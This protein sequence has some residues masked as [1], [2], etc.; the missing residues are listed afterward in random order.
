MRSLPV[1]GALVVALTFAAPSALAA[2]CDVNNCTAQIEAIN[3][4]VINDV[5]TDANGNTA[6]QLPVYGK[7]INNWPNCPE[8]VDFAGAGHSIAPFDC[9]SQYVT[10]ATSPTVAAGNAFLGAVDRLWWQPCRLADPTLSNGCVANWSCIA[11]GL[12]GNYNPWQGLV[13]DLGGPS[14]RVAVFAENDHGPQPCESLEYTVY[15]SDNPYA[16]DVVLD[17]KTTGV[18]PNKW[19]RAVLSKIYTA[20]WVQVRPPD[21]GPYGAACGDTADYSVEEDS[22]V[23]VFSLPCG[24]TFR[25]ASVVAGNDGL[26]FPACK[27]DSNEGEIDAVAGLTESGAA[28]CPDADHDQYVDC[29]CMGAPPVCDCNDADPGIHPG[30]PEA[31]DSP[32]LNCDGAPS[33]CPSPLACYQSVCLQACPG[34]EFPCPAG[35]SCTTTPQGDLCVPMDCTVGGCPPGGVCKGGVCVPA[36]TNVVCP[37]NQQ[38]VDGACKDLCAGVVCP[39]GQLCQGGQCR[40]L[41]SCFAGDV[42]CASQPGTV[43]DVANGGICSDPDCAGVS[44]TAPETCDPATGQCVP[45]CHPGV[46]CPDGEKCVDPQGCVPNCEGVT[47]DPGFACDP[48]TGQCHDKCDGVS[49]F[50]PLV[51]VD[52]QCVESM[53]TTSGSTTASSGTGSSSGGQGGASGQVSPGSGCGCRID[54]QA[55]ARDVGAALLAMVGLAGVAAR[56]RHRRAARAPESAAR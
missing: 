17:P 37:G 50:A 30:A 23:Q 40:V 25:Y 19:N 14:N 24:I 27:Y 54:G 7:L 16:G 34:P 51:C 21:Q 42:G 49:C 53:T 33:P 52:G 3:G 47:C 8:H 35:S 48:K 1:L 43:C 26:D 20:G 36:C 55:D 9:P 44:C 4:V 31:C 15:L 39:A 2:P 46:V 10:D 6:Q 18:D 45:F 28:V 29:N 38:C 12:G 13:F 32:D 5:F 56:R 22:F 41:C 11:D